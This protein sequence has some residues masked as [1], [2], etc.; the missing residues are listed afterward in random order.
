MYRDWDPN[1]PYKVCSRSTGACMT[2]PTASGGKVTLA[3][4]TGALNQQWYVT[5]VNPS[6]YR[7][8]SA[9]SG[10]CVVPASGTAA[11]LLQAPYTGATNQLWTIQPHDGAYGYYFNCSVTSSLCAAVTGT[12]PGTIENDAFHTI[13]AQQWSITPLR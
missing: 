8:C 6:Q 12:A 2:A 5:R 3:N 9:S 1:T 4:T 10:L 13:S 11:A 7:I